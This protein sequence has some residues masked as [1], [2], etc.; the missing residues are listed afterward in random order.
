MA[1]ELDALFDRINAEVDDA[2]SS[3]ET[4]LNDAPAQ[5][6][7]GVKKSDKTKKR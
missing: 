1:A 7:S 6:R 4:A 2:L 3:L 5:P